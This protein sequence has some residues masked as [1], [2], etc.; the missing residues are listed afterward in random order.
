VCYT[1]KSY[2]KPL[3]SGTLALFLQIWLLVIS[4]IP[5]EALG[6][7]LHGVLYALPGGVFSGGHQTSNHRLQGYDRVVTLEASQDIFDH[8][9][10]ELAALCLQA[11]SKNLVPAPE[12]IG[13]GIQHRERVGD[14]RWQLRHWNRA[15]P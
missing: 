12:V 13:G 3:P 15:H 14:R 5:L 9:P 4:R 1:T 11:G 10:V 7:Q 8:R 2:Y 6:H